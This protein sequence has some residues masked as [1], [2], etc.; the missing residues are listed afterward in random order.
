MREKKSHQKYKKSPSRVRSW[1]KPNFGGFSSP[2]WKAR[3]THVPI[4]QSAFENT[5]A[6]TH[7]HTHA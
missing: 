7:T 6:H 2:E 1:I 4:I 3:Q 5:H